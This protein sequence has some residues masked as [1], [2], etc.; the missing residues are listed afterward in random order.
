MGKMEGRSEQEGK[1][2]PLQAWLK[3]QSARGEGEKLPSVFLPGP[4]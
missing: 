3:N 1:N 4:L 2:G